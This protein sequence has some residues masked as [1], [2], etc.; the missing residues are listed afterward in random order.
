M[1]EAPNQRP[2]NG[3]DRSARAVRAAASGPRKT[4]FSEEKQSINTADDDG[5]NTDEHNDPPCRSD[6]S[7]FN[8]DTILYN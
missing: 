3:H 4:R 2:G 1:S 6:I 5:R 8:D 7:V